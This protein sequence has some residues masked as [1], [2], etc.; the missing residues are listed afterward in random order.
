MRCWSKYGV[1]RETGR[2]S[3]G[4]ILGYPVVQLE[5]NLERTNQREQ[6][7]FLP[8]QSDLSDENNMEQLF[9]CSPWSGNS[10]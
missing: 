1:Y 9:S 10:T 7:C 2:T 6:S 3:K 5:A 8:Q 4:V